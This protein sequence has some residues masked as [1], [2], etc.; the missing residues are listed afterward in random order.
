MCDMYCYCI[1][2][3]RFCS[4]TQISSDI[5]ECTPTR[6]CYRGVRSVF[7]TLYL[8]KIKIKMVGHKK[9]EMK[10]NEKIVRYVK[11]NMPNFLS[12]KRFL[13]FLS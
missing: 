8:G 2:N 3:L 10:M 1:I 4:Y 13:S 12:G 5:G 11:R 6:V 9:N 7:P